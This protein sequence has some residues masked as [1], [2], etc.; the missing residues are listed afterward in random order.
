MQQAIGVQPLDPLGIQDIGLGTGTTV[1]ELPWLD[2]IDCKTFHFEQFEERHPVDAGG[3]HGDRGDAV[4]A[5]IGDDGLQIGGV[6]AEFADQT[7]ADT[8]DVQVGMDI[9]AGGVWIVYGERGRAVLK[10]VWG[11]GVEELLRFLQSTFGHDGC[12]LCK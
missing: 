11:V 4:G 9:N 6:G 5:E 12:T 10:G 3:F 7:G 2:Q 1:L 8:D